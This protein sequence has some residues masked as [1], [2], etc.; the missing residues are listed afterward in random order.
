[1]VRG[2]LTDDRWRLMKPQLPARKPITGRPG[3]DRR[4]IINGV[5]WFLRAGA[6]R[7]NLRSAVGLVAG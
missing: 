5:W 3:K 4:M 2:D 6:P 1:M 7:P